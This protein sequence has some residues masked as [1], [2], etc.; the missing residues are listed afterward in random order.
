M[1]G[2]GNTLSED[3]DYAP[4]PNRAIW[5]EGQLN[6]ALLERLR[7][8][9]FELVAQNRNPITVFINSPGGLHGVPEGI[10]SLLRRTTE[11]DARAS[12]IITVAAPKA[13]SA[14]AELLSA[15][16][17]AIARPHSALLYHGLRWQLDDRQLTGE[18]ARLGR[19]L[20]TFH[21]NA[22]AALARN[23]F[24]RFRFIISSKRALF[25]QH[26]ADKSNPALTDL[27]CFQA[28]LRTDLSPAAQEVLELAI[29]LWQSYNSLLLHFQKKLRRGRTVTKEHLQM[30][31]M[32]ASIACDREGH[33]GESR[34]DGG[35]SNISDHF[36]FLNAYFDIA[37]LCDWLAASAE[38][39][40]IDVDPEEAYFLQFRVFFLALCRA[41]QE[42]ENYITPMDALW[43]G[44]VDTVRM[45]S[46]FP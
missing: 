31:M 41:L 14:A 3:S 45:E 39:Q 22:A 25:A 10:L 5:V 11:D 19:T 44:L 43:F 37:R 38:T 36:Y 27:E 29:P 17:F 1:N 2:S 42:G 15:G 33:N 26:R 32:Y 30:L 16:D 40:T 9:I 6:E 8:E 13:G 4:N 18:R 7:P 12:R 34:W 46:S 24:R 35:W 28:I 23:S 20:P 21:E